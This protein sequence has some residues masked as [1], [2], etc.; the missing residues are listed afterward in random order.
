MVLGLVQASI[1]GWSGLCKKM[2]RCESSVLGFAWGR[3]KNVEVHKIR[4]TS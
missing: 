3:R 2:E 1:D 4:A